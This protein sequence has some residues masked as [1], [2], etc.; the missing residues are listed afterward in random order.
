MAKNSYKKITSDG[1]KVS[2]ISLLFFQWMS[3]VFKTGNERGLEETD[4]LPLLKE[5]TP[6]SVIGQ[7]Q[8]KWNKEVRKFRENGER[9]KLW[10]SVLK[11]L[12][13]NTLSRILQPLFLGY[14]IVSL[15]SADTA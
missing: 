13:V 2:F 5:N 8:T 14:L 7:L 9:P 12:S 15:M 3:S 1:D 10:K 11:M 6:C 4:L